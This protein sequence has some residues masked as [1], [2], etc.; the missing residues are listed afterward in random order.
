[1]YDGKILLPHSISPSSNAVRKEWGRDML[2]SPK[3]QA[4]SE[5]TRPVK[6]F[7]EVLLLTSCC[8]CRSG[9]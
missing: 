3:K 2:R 9:S 8:G 6:N 7:F 5:M 1:M 4:A